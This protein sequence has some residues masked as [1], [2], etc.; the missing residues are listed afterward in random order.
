MAEPRVVSKS[1]RVRSISDSSFVVVVVCCL[2]WVGLQ[3]CLQL[4]TARSGRPPVHTHLGS[5]HGDNIPTK[6]ICC[7]SGFVF[8]LLCLPLALLRWGKPWHIQWRSFIHLM[9]RH[10]T[11][12]EVFF[13]HLVLHAVTVCYKAW[14]V[15]FPYLRQHTILHTRLGMVVSHLHWIIIRGTWWKEGYVIYWDKLTL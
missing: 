6:K 1:Y 5:Y 8:S 7:K 15:P 14:T 10:I 3:E 9:S 11:A 4:A 13:S 2:P 12:H